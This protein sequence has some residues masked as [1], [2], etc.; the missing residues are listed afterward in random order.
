MSTLISALITGGFVFIKKMTPGKYETRVEMNKKERLELEKKIMRDKAEPQGML[1][2]NNVT[3]KAAS[4]PYG[5]GGDPGI[6]KKQRREIEKKVM[7]NLAEKI[8]GPGSSMPEKTNEEL[9][10]VWQR[11]Q[12]KPDALYDPYREMISAELCERGLEI[13]LPIHCPQSP[14][15][16]LLD[17]MLQEEAYGH[18]NNTSPRPP[19][20]VLEAMRQQWAI[21]TPMFPK[22]DVPAS[23]SELKWRELKK[24]EEKERLLQRLHA[25]MLQ[26][27]DGAATAGR[28]AR[29]SSV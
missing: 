15:E 4:T 25:S 23:S 2:P 27:Q 29:R 24:I 3:Q 16:A 11:L 7:R 18:L 8:T 14:A 13:P 17:S 6:G 21:S 26:K 20:H 28:P 22:D 10:A 9:L 1:S 19:Q 5:K 12:D